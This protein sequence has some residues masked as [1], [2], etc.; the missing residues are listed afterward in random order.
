MRSGCIELS[1]GYRFRHFECR[2]SD[3]Y[4]IVNIYTDVRA[5][6]EIMETKYLTEHEHDGKMIT[7]FM[8][9]AYI[10]RGERVEL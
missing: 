9:V 8:P 5:T 3:I 10:V 6:G 7:G 4:T 2:Y 1:V